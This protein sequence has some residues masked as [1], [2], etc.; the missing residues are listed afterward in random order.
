MRIKQLSCQPDLLQG[1]STPI[2]PK[3]ESVPNLYQ[4]QTFRRRNETRAI[5]MSC[6]QL[7]D[8]FVDVHFVYRD[9]CH[10]PNYVLDFFVKK[11][12]P[13]NFD[14]DSRSASPNLSVPNRSNC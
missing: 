6:L 4:V 7:R 1:H 13:C 14:C 2:T 11:T 8:D 10:S 5:S 12:V 9:L 3:A